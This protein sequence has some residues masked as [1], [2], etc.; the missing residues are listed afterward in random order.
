MGF[1]LVDCHVMLSCLQ[2]QHPKGRHFLQN[3]YMPRSLKVSQVY[4]RPYLK[5]I[6]VTY[7]LQDPELK[8]SAIQLF[9][10]TQAG[11]HSA[12]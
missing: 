5:K 10:S 12:L 9:L 2:P 8:Q 3:A 1:L 4:V 7:R 6:S 11:V